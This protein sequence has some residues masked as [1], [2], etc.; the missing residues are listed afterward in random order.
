MI[1]VIAESF[2]PLQGPVGTT[3]DVRVTPGVINVPAG[4]L[5]IVG[6]S[7]YAIQEGTY[8]PC[9]A[10]IEDPQY[11]TRFQI[12]VPAGIGVGAHCGF[13]ISLYNPAGDVWKIVNRPGVE[14]VVTTSDS[15]LTITGLTPNRI[16]KS[17]LLSTVI[18]VSGQSLDRL[19]L[20][21]PPTLLSSPQL[22]FQYVST[23]HDAVRIRILAGT[24]ITHLQPGRY[25]VRFANKFSGQT[26]LSRSILS[27]VP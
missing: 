18:T 11:Y 12:L 7:L 21:Y 15:R 4:T 1:E 6:A 16:Q 27:I 25:Q 14:F 8:Y 3:I 24:D 17:N 26:V 19:D 10:Q 13:S 5:N 2:A 23:A 9:V 22:R 20:A